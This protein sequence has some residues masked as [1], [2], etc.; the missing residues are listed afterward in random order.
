MFREA[1]FFGLR[2]WPKIS[3]VIAAYD[4]ERTLKP[5]LD[6][7]TRLNYPDYEVILVDDGSTDSTPQIAG[8]Y[9]SVR[10]FRHEKNFGLSVARNTGIEAATGELIAF[11]DA[12]CRADEDWLYY[13]AAELLDNG[14]AGIGGP[15]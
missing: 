4:A 15:N 6:S 8:A 14:F 10:F 1:P 13:L 9:P 11:T 5:C 7:L 3:V 12:D 2:R